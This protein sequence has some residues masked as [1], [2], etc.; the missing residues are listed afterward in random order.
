[1]RHTFTSCGLVCLLICGL[2]A[3]ATAAD[4]A[5]QITAT[6]NASSPTFT[7]AG[8]R[9]MIRFEDYVSNPQPNSSQPA[10]GHIVRPKSP[11][12]GLIKPSA[13]FTT[14]SPLPPAVGVL[15]ES[16]T[17][18]DFYDHTSAA[19]VAKPMTPVTIRFVDPAD[20]D[21]A[22]TVSHFAFTAVGKGVG[23]RDLT[24][25]VYDVAG[26]K[27][28]SGKVEPGLDGNAFTASLEL[29]A[30]RAGKNISAIHRIAFTT[31]GGAGY[32]VIGATTTSKGYDLAYAGFKVTDVSLAASNPA[33]PALIHAEQ[34]TRADEA[35]MLT[36]MSRVKPDSALADRRLR[37]KWKVMEYETE[38]FSGKVITVGRESFAEPVTLELDQRGWHAVYVGMMTMIDFIKAGSNRVHARLT[39]DDAY[40]RLSNNLNVGSPVRDMIEDVYLGA[41][42][43]TGQDIEFAF[44][45]SEPAT[46]AYVKLVPLT[47]EE[48]RRI[49]EDRAQTDTRRLIATFD[50]H[51]IVNGYEVR[52]RQDLA[53]SYARLNG[54]DFG[55]WWVQM[56]GADLTHYPTEIGTVLGS[57]VETYPRE[58]DRRYNE[59]LE[60]LFANGVHP[61]KVAAEEAAKQNAK[62]IICTRMAGWAGGPPWEEYFTSAFYEAHPEFRCVD[63]EGKPTMH[64]SY[65][66]EQVQDHVVEALREALR[67]GGDGAGVLFHRGLPYILW[68]DAFCD[69]FKAKYGEDPRKLPEDDPRV[70]AM[71]AEIITQYLRKIRAMLDEV[72]RE[73]G[74]DK[75]L[76]LAVSTYSNRMD[77]TKYGLDVETWISEKLIDQI[78]IAWFAFHTSGLQKREAGMDVTYYAGITEG[79]G[80]KVYPFLIGWSIPTPDDVLNFAKKFYEQGADGIAFWDPV[81]ETGWKGVGSMW[82]M[83]S[84]LGHVEELETREGKLFHYRPKVTPVT[85]LDQNY[86]SKWFPNTGF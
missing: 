22:A 15:L 40:T 73:R 70:H 74:S 24:V 67:I 4:D 31:T 56:V 13:S 76:E 59:A 63:Y 55:T 83:I 53:N 36:D 2:P 71:R 75:R 38:Q 17:T 43:L 61:I 48:V 29:S 16:P 46:I 28:Y 1:M 42:D 49:E 77:N 41:A 54:S 11:F 25:E 8:D 44:S 64:L 21:K 80:V 5:V 57:N 33:W 12:H 14:K 52:T 81:P 60:N 47:A 66:N 34:W 85:R 35:V 7:D 26:D 6:S 3:D 23:S 86:Y 72:Q 39:G 79:T 69:R 84:R 18:I 58:V 62:L 45:P 32:A 65:A 10:S 19:D 9:V 27:L 51:H 37:G 50:G 82:P 20:P 78:G 30:Q 68:E